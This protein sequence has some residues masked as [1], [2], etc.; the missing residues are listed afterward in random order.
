MDKMLNISYVYGVCIC[1]AMLL[2]IGYCTLASKKEKNFIGLFV[3]ILII[4]VG[5][6][7]LSISKTVEMALMSNR[8]AYLGSVF[9][10]L[11]MLYIIMNACN[12]TCPKKVCVAL[13][14]LSIAVFLIAASQGYCRL[15]YDEV[16]LVIKDG[17]AKLLRTYG[18][19]HKI[20]YIYLFTSFFAMCVVAVVAAIK[21]KVTALKH[22]GI[23][24]VIVTLNIVIWLVEQ[25][26]DWNFEFLSVSYIASGCLLLLVYG[27]ML[28][29]E[30][31]QQ[32]KEMENSPWEKI[33]LEQLENSFPVTQ[34]LSTR[35]KEVLLALLKNIKR[36]EIASE[37][38]ISENTVKK[39]IT[40]IYLKL[41]V[42]GRE[43]LMERLKMKEQ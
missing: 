33:S 32:I 27:V 16:S 26:I 35:E 19:L 15:Y 7:S 4:N 28:D 1:L 14:L 12:V 25:G 5:Y 36:K 41:E 17:A 6:F 8:V 29:Y 24:V 40:N 42:S 2:L 34:K 39:H 11:F 9:L 21:K 30:K 3:L 23:L 13:D 31:L 20:Y 10:P 43:E 22:V 18:P 37:L 38:F